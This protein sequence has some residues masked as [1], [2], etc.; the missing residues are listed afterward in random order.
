MRDDQPWVLATSMSTT[1]SPNQVRQF[2]DW[3]GSWQD[4]QVYE[5]RAIEVLLRHGGFERA[6][7]LF[8]F[9]CG[10]GRLAE[11]L[12]Q[13]RLPADAFYT[14]VDISQTMVQLAAARVRP[15]AGRA[16]VVRS[17]G[18]PALDAPDGRFDRFI[19]AY[20]LD[21]LGDSDIRRLLAEAYRVLAADGYL[22]LASLTFGGALRSRLITTLWRT[23][24]AIHPLTVGGCRP[25]RLLQYVSPAHWRVSHRELVT[26]WGVASEVVVAQRGSS[27]SREDP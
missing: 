2:Y 21:L 18:S 15:W 25:V 17:T 4:R 26:E 14:G 23:A 7:A 19:A 6:H 24:Y 8:E 10:T 1:P 3:F 13:H 20:V 12:L 16:T 5:R 9:G 27:S 22:C 11:R